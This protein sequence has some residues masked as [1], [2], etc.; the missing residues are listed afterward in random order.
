MIRSRQGVPRASFQVQPGEEVEEFRVIL[1]GSSALASPESDRVMVIRGNGEPRTL[2]SEP[3][4]RWPL[5]VGMSY[6]EIL[7]LSSGQGVD[8][9]R[10]VGAED[11]LVL[12]WVAYE[13]D[14]WG[15]GEVD[16]LT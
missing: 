9:G 15:K 16:R 10:E 6:H 13:E 11:A 5:A 3:N 8:L 12:S 2:L 7:C 14:V 4:V 1:G